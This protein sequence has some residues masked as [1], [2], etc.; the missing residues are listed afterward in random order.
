[1][2]HDLD[3]M[4]D[5]RLALC[6]QP[7][8]GIGDRGRAEA[9]DTGNGPAGHSGELGHCGCDCVRGD[10]LMETLKQ[11]AERVLGL[12]AELPMGGDIP[13]FIL[14]GPDTRIAQLS[15]DFD[16]MTMREAGAGDFD[17]PIAVLY[18]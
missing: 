12:S 4:G 17:D 2:W 6:G 8:V 3:P 11:F 16:V 9:A 1:M 7:A 14:G 13:M 5:R 15:G 10:S 18:T